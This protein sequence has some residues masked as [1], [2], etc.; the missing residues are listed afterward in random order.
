MLHLISC[1]LYV[2][3]LLSKSHLH[4]RTCTPLLKPP[5]KKLKHLV[6]NLVFKKLKDFDLKKGPIPL[7]LAQNFCANVSLYNSR[8][9]RQIKKKEFVWFGIYTQRQNKTIQV[10]NSISQFCTDQLIDKKVQLKQQQVIQKLKEIQTF[11]VD[12]CLIYI[13]QKKFLLYKGTYQIQIDKVYKIFYLQKA[14]SSQ[15]HNPPQSKIA[16]HQYQIN[17]P[18][19]NSQRSPDENPNYIYKNSLQRNS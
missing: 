7:K 19:T 15:Y 6:L 11:N 9:V 5:F 1:A 10:T 13:I 17:K 14:P 12:L 2:K 8:N 18:N 16:Q 4:I 3:N